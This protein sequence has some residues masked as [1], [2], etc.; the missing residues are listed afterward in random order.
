MFKRKL[1][2]G[3]VQYGEWYTDPLTDKRKRITITLTPTGRKKT[4]DR[5]A[6]EALRARIRASN[7]KTGSP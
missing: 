1:P 2:S 3:R 7:P 4:D 6:E 5:T